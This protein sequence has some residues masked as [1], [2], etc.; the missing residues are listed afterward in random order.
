MKAKF[1]LSGKIE[2]HYGGGTAIART[3]WY[4]TGSPPTNHPERKKMPRD[5][6][7]APSL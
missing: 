5:A 3:R 6:H 1:T 2:D 7:V 4:G